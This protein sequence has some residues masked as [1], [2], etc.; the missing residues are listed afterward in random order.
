MSAPRAALA[1]PVESVACATILHPARWHFS[2]SLFM[3]R[4]GHTHVQ[5]ETVF[6]PRE[7]PCIGRAERL[8]P[9]RESLF[10]K[11]T[12]VAPTTLVEAG[13]SVAFRLALIA[14]LLMTMLVLSLLNVSAVERI[15]PR[16][17][18]DIAPAPS[19][20]SRFTPR[21]PAR[22]ATRSH[23]SVGISASPDA[24]SGNA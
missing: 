14:L 8:R 17:A 21:V 22:A 15:A 19:G 20:T 3:R 1:L 4:N 6:E 23:S 11:P 16:D 18:Q 24:K 5:S 12:T 10:V 9:S 2:C 7:R 13:R